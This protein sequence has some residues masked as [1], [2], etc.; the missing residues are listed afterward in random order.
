MLIFSVS[1]HGSDGDGDGGGYGDGDGDRDDNMEVSVLLSGTKLY[2]ATK[3]VTHPADPTT[4]RPRP[5]TPLDTTN[6]SKFG[7][8]S[9]L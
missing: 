5:P 7:I 2:Q 6:H 9:K 1:F 3:V 8:A 4:T